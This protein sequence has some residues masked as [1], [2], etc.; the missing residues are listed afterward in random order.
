MTR[1]TIFVYG[2]LMKGECNHF[3]IQNQQYKGKAVIHG[4]NLYSLGP[5]PGIRPS[6]YKHRTVSGELYSIDEE[7]LRQVNRLEGEGSLYLLRYTEAQTSD[8]KTERAGIYVYNSICRKDSWIMDGDWKNRNFPTI[9]LAYGSNMNS[10]QMLMERCP[11]AKKLG[12]AYL[13]NYRL[14]FR[15][16]LY[17][18][19]VA[20]IDRESGSS[21]P[22]VLWAITKK[23]EEKLD[24]KE[25]VWNHN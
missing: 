15:I 23:H 14:S 20:T 1:T 6:K 17:N 7:A 12:V 21:V 25:G 18:H 3:L 5:Y 11:G 9:Y 19:A 2:T 10:H 22:V 16:N 4:F 8:G 24:G 13:K